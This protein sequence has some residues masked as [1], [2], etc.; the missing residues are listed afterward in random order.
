MKKRN[1]IKNKST[2]IKASAFL[3]SIKISLTQHNSYKGVEIIMAYVNFKEERASV[4]E[5]LEKRKENNKEIFDNILKTK[6]LHKIYKPD[7]KY[8]Y[9]EHRDKKFGLE[10]VKD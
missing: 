9:K 5:Q 4:K 7:S 1:L 3:I 6:D 2:C 10:G 8:S